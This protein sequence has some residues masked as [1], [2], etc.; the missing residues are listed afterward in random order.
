MTARLHA[1]EA[2]VLATQ[3]QLKIA[4]AAAGAHLGKGK[5]N[6]SGSPIPK[7]SGHQQPVQL[8]DIGP[9]QGID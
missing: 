2:T 4:Q 3:A 1:L 6:H 8:V 9:C 5:G 7:Q